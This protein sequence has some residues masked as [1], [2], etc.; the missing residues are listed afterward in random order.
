MAWILRLRRVLVLIRLFGAGLLVVRLLWEAWW[1]M[2]RQDAAGVLLFR[3]CGWQ[4]G[5]PSALTVQLL[6]VRR[7]S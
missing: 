3:R 1:D 6:Y 2:C 4:V 5:D 7:K